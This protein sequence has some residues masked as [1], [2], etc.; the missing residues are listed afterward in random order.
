MGDDWSSMLEYASQ[1]GLEIKSSSSF[2]D[3]QL[4]ARTTSETPSTLS[5]VIELAIAQFGK[6]NNIT[7]ITKEL[8]LPLGGPIKAIGY[9]DYT[10]EEIKSDIRMD[11]DVFLKRHHDLALNMMKTELELLE[12]Q[13]GPLQLFYKIHIKSPSFF[14]LTFMFLQDAPPLNSK[15]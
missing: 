8:P 11:C 15:M 6:E 10:L 7:L 14:Y 1:N 4:G 9:R 12:H 13:S 2:F 5:Q 3:N